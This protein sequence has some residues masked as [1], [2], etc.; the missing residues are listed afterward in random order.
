MKKIIGIASTI[1]ILII[2]IFFIKNNYK[3]IKTGNNIS[4]KSIDEIKE[5][6]LNIE[7]YNANA[8][9]EISSN[10]TQNTYIMEQEYK[11]EGNL[12]TQKVLEP[13]NLSEIEF[14]Y[15]GKDL[16][17]KNSK[18]SLNK[19][20]TDYKFMGSNELSLIKFI[21]DYK[22]N[23]D[24]KI[25]EENGKVIMEVEVK[26]NNIYT[27]NKKLTINK[28]K[29]TIEKLEIKDI[30]QKTTIYILY[31]KIEINKLTKEEMVA[32]SNYPINAEI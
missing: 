15:D 6:I 19:I 14:T 5:Y 29:N 7:S 25:Y 4:N 31:N 24:T 1:I 28:E 18:L 27:Q 11:K 22:Q 10:K 3:K 2:I 32:F 30:T 13:E 8:K 12:Y 26:Q 16:N 23:Q 20:Y 21:E 17:I 9:I